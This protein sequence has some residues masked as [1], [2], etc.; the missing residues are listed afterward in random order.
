M[1]NVVD[2]QITDEEFVIYNKNVNIGVD[3]DSSHDHNTINEPKCI[4]E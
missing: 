4:F 1:E 3:T 2:H